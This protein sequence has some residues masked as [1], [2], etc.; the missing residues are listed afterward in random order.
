MSGIT[1]L[2]ALERIDAEDGTHLTRD[3]L[4]GLAELYR[5]NRTRMAQAA[6]VSLTTLWRYMRRHVGKTDEGA[7]ENGKPQSPRKP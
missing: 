4:L 6:G 5:W 3:Y 2:A 7:P 1:Y